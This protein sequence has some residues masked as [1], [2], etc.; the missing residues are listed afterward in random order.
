MRPLNHGGQKVDSRGFTL[1][2][3]MIASS[4]F[5]VI[6]LICTTAMLQIGK[7]YYR[8]IV[9]SKTQES[10]R[11]IMD[12]ISRQ[13]QF[14]GGKLT[15]D[16]DGGVDAYCIDNTKYSFKLNTQVMDSVD[17]PLYQGK[18]ALVVEDNVA[19]C[20]SAAM[21]PLDIN[22]TTL[23]LKDTQRELLE[24][25][26]RLTEFSISQIGTS[27]MY[28]VKVKVVYGVD[29]DLEKDS[30]GNILRCKSITFGSQFC[31]ISELT[32]KVEQRIKQ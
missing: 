1:V 23:N 20:S 25:H 26:M 18:Y 22:D 19:D 8:G 7:T 31:A 10:T 3:L 29:D 28:E 32:T 4:V 14:N 15:S 2:E 13:L 6:L 21:T 9:V 11:S 5:S 12:T 16:I 24:Q 30:L 27:S 17:D